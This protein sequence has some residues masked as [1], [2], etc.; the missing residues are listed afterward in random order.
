[1]VRRPSEESWFY[2]V[3]VKPHQDEV[4]EKILP[5][6][7]CGAAPHLCRHLVWMVCAKNWLSQFAA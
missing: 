7:A 6:A 1:L 4:I 5:T 3:A 2:V